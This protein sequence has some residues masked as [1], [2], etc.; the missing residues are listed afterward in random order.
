MPSK[1]KRQLDFIGWLWV[2]R[3]LLWVDHVIIA[4]IFSYTLIGGIRGLVDEILSLAGWLLAIWL[5]LT[6][7]REFSILLTITV[8]NPAV[9]VGLSF[10]GLL[11]I[12]LLIAKA[13]KVLLAD[14]IKTTQIG[15][16][17]RFW[18]M[19]LGSVQGGIVVALL[20]LLAG[21]SPLPKDAWWH[22][23]LWIPPFQSLA[24]FMRDTIPSEM[25]AYVNYH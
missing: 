5:G 20:I 4:I 23:A 13:L 18:A 25:S 17:N 14:V 24:I 8:T 22:Q 9:K 1:N 21:L 12:T 19:L 3:I 7:N 11:L 15:F 10:V 2:G 16:L 6:F